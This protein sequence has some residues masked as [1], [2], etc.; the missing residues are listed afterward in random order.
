[1]RPLPPVVLVAP[2]VGFFITGHSAVIPA[3]RQLTGRTREALAVSLPANAII[4]D[5][6][7]ASLA[8]AT[9]AE[10]APAEVPAAEPT[11]AEAPAAAGTP[12]GE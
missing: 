3:G 2:V 4:N 9:Q 11:P 1:M 10:T 7:R 5:S 6:V 12:Q 8:S